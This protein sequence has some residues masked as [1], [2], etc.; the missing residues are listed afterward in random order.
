MASRNLHFA[1]YDI[2]DHR[3]LRAAL[4][5]VRSYATGGQKSA[6]EVFLTLRERG[7]LLHDM[8]HV[9]DVDEDRFLLV[10]LDPRATTLTLGVA[11][12]P[13][14]PQMFYVA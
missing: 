1:A 13:A 12:Q 10:Q 3:R 11:V 2:C 9:L 7:D 14:D 5:V 4:D 8:A 6:Y